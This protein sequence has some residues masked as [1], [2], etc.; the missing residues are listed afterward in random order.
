MT[1]L[2]K[3]ILETVETRSLINSFEP[4]QGNSNVAERCQQVAA[5]EEGNALACNRVLHRPNAPS[6][7]ERGARV[8]HR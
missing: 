2:S 7:G 1:R 3:Y 4:L 6:D 5:G 8:L